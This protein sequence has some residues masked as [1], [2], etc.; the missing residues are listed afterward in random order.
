MMHILSV[1]LGSPVEPYVEAATPTMIDLRCES[2]NV[3]S[4]KGEMI[5]R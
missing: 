2:S 1:R 5:R 3:E 4:R